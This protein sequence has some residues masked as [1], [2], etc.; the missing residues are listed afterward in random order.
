VFGIFFVTDMTSA[1]RDLW[2]MVRPG[3]QLAITSWGVPVFEPATQVFWRAIEAERPDLV[4]QFTPWDRIA[5]PASL[6]ALLEAGGA[7][8]VEVFAEVGT[9]ALDAPEDWWTMALG[10]GLRGTID[11]LDPAAQ[12]RVKQANLQ[13]LRTNEVHSLDVKVLYAIA[14][15]V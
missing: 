12:A 4:K 3:G 9:H 14:Q 5:D 10:G 2:R 7:T 13:F 11:Q 1:I 6:Q 15:K 8:S